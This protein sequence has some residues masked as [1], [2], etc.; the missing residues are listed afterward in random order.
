MQ[1][2]VRFSI[3]HPLTQQQGGRSGVAVIQKS[4]QHTAVNIPG[5]KGWPLIEVVLLG[6]VGGSVR[7]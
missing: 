1:R 2:R 7:Y 4:P 3:W 6:V 5:S